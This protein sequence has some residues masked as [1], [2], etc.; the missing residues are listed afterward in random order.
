MLTSTMLADTVL[1][2]EHLVL[3]G[4]SALKMTCAAC[5]TFSG[6]IA[7][8]LHKDGAIGIMEACKLSSKR[9]VAATACAAWPTPGIA[10]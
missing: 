9:R 4:Q 2:L 1:K 10:G 7:S 5:S 3:S 8:S 6:P